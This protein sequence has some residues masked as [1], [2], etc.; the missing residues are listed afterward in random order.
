MIITKC[1]S[2]CHIPGN[3]TENWLICSINIYWRLCYMQGARNGAM[4]IKS[5]WLQSGKDYWDNTVLSKISSCWACIHKNMEN[6]LKC[7]SWFSISEAKPE[8]ESESGVAQSCPSLCDLV[9][10]SPPGS[11]VLGF[12]RQE[13]W[14]GLPF[15]SPEDLPDPGIE[16][17]SPALQADALTFEPQ[18]SPQ[19]KAKYSTILISTFVVPT[20]L[21]DGPQVEYKNNDSLQ[22]CILWI[23][24]AK[25]RCV[26]PIVDFDLYTILST[27]W[28]ILKLTQVW[29]PLMSPNHLTLQGTERVNH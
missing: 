22:A 9:D 1:L 3:R 25:C 2:H 14:S 19:G 20:M 16:P 23:T 7:R 27:P 4:K 13:Y 15:P 24:F 29:G 11:S 28:I 10:C 6:L 8:S 26:T 5:Q 18:G 17:R 12:S 21:K